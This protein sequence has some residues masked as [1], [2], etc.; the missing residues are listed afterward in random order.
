MFDALIIKK[1]LN[2]GVPELGP[3]ITCYLLDW[4]TKFLLCSPNKGLYLFLYL[5]LIKDKEYPSETGIIIN[6]NRSIFITPD[7]RKGNRSKE[8]HMNQL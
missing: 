5:T 3:I 7:T 8:I 6:N 4:E 2:L 1:L